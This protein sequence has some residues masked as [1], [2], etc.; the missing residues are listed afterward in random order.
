MDMVMACGFEK[1][2]DRWDAKRYTESGAHA[3]KTQPLDR[4]NEDRNR[5]QPSFQLHLLFFSR[6]L[7]AKN[8]GNMHV[9]INPS[10]RTTYTSPP[11]HK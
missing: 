3:H 1:V 2:N 11:Y 7:P 4:T 5:A 6:P 9:S 8:Q 10:F